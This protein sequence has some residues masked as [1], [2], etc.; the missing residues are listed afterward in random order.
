M[1]KKQVKTKPA[2][3]MVHIRLPEDIH[4]KVRVQAAESDTTIQDWV[5]EAIQEYL[6]PSGEQKVNKA[7]K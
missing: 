5:L 7:K 4:K 3:R 6:K 1:N 2:I